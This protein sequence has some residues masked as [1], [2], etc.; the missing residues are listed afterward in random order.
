MILLDVL[1]PAQLLVP[2]LIAGLALNLTPG[3]DMT[4]VAL[5]GSRGGRR[6]GLDASVTSCSPLSGSRH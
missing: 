2:F 1:P 3:S 4:F 6:V 5:S